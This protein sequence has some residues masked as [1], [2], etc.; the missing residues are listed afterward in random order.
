MNVSTSIYQI[1]TLT[2]G[3]AYLESTTSNATTGTSTGD[4]DIHGHQFSASFSRDIS[5]RMTAGISGG[6]AFRTQDVRGPDAETNYRVWN[7]SLFDNYALPNRIEIRVNIGVTKL[8]TEDPFVSTVSSLSYWFG[9]A[10]ASVGVVRGLS[11]TF[12]GG[13]NQGVV[14][15]TGATGSLTYPF[16]PSFR[17]VASVAYHENE[18][19]AIGG[20]PAT[21]ALG[22][23]TEK[24]L[25][26]SIGVTFQILRWL[27]SGLGYSY[28][29][30]T[31]SNV[32][33]DIVEN[34]VTASLNFA[35]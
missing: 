33:G 5:Q 2:V 10:V 9:Q 25:V 32:D 23:R 7:V 28:S 35:F 21:T 12:S 13:Q 27:G 15:T 26:G 34:R 11:E 17:G 29:S 16:T 18:F 31:A 30:T 6:Y 19:T 14:K 22:A 4:S 20:A 8:S 24:V 3:Y 1:H